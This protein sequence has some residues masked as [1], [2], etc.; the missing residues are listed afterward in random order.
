MI[1]LGL[2]VLIATCTVIREGGQQRQN[3]FWV[4]QHSSQ[5][6][7]RAPYKINIMGYKVLAQQKLLEGS[8]DLP[9]SHRGPA[10]TPGE[11][12]FPSGT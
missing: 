4:N 1:V 9:L 2:V 11:C 7:V 12:V 5:T 10:E 3:A 8:L 6:Q